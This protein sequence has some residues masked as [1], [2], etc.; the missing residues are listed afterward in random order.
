MWYATILV[1]VATNTSC[2]LSIEWAFVIDIYS[3]QSMKTVCKWM[4]SAVTWREGI[5][6]TPY[7]F[8][9]MCVC[10]TATEWIVLNSKYKAPNLTCM[11]GVEFYV[12]K[13]STSWI[14]SCAISSP[15]TYSYL[16]MVI[17][18]Q[19]PTFSLWLPLRLCARFPTQHRR[20]ENV[21]ITEWLCSTDQ[22]E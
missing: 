22:L 9:A 5:Q 6:Y 19:L 14:K 1:S 21:S 4:C 16:L 3:A 20:I 15:L 12:L 7:A 13:I 11:R 2:I 8:I 10:M 17:P 18:R